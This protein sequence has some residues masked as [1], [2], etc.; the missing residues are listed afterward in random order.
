ML[1]WSKT[2]GIFT[3]CFKG[4]KQTLKHVEYTVRYQLP[5]NSY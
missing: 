2:N 3:H 1:L 4:S 5:C